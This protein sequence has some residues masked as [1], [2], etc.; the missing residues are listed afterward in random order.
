ME[1]RTAAVKTY[2][3]IGGLLYIKKLMAKDGEAWA[4][5][6]SVN[7]LL[8]TLPLLHARLLTEKYDQLY[9]IKAV[10]K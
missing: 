9:V 7:V 8:P 6:Y 3:F 1:V 10:C 2:W 5:Q 4:R